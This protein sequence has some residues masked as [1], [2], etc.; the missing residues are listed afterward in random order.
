MEIKEECV[1][2]S[3]NSKI[4]CEENKRKIVFNNSSNKNVSKILVDGCQITE[5]IRCD[6][7]ITFNTDEHFV[8]L[9]GKDITHAFKQL[10]RTITLLKNSTCN[11][12]VSYI[13]SS[14]SPLV[15]ASIQVERLKFRKKYQSELIVKNNNYQVKI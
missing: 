4:V 8:E 14:R 13:I 11:N 9:K 6:Y 2:V 3:N 5:G 15:A 12:R 1:K 10:I 7:L